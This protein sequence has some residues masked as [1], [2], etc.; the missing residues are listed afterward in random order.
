MPSY[1]L[2]FSTATCLVYNNDNNSGYYPLREG[3][4]SHVLYYNEDGFEEYDANKATY[5]VKQTIGVGRSDGKGTVKKVAVQKK[6][7]NKAVSLKDIVYDK[8]SKDLN[9]DLRYFT[10]EQLASGEVAYWLNYEGK[11][12]T[13]D[14]TRTWTQGSEVP[15]MTTPDS[16]NATHQLTYKVANGSN[17]V[18]DVT[19]YANEGSA[20]RISLNKD[21]ES[22]TVDGTPA[23]LSS[24]SKDNVFYADFTTPVSNNG[25]VEVE[26]VYEAGTGIKNETA[27]NECN[28]RE[29]NGEISADCDFQIFSLMGQ[30]VTS[31]NGK[32]SKGI[33]LVKC[34]TG[35]TTQVIVQ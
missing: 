3:T 21:P 18:T 8:D 27:D 15:E 31:L 10:D 17:N 29:K 16:N 34:A 4:I 26:I 25:E 35:T 22:V 12:Y 23:I 32:L 5:I 11:G 14:F 9:D 1:L 6:E 30:D 24:D 20:V 33:Y 19:P 7:A 13:G 2:N 28:V